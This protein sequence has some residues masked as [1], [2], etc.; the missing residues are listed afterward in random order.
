[1]R[2]VTLG[3]MQDFRINVCRSPGDAPHAARM[4]KPEFS[5]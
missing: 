3:S 4:G 5:G 1:M 2:E